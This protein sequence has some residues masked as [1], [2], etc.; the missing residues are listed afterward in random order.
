[1]NDKELR[2]AILRKM[3][4]H[5]WIGGKHIALDNIPKGFPSHVR[6]DVARVAESLIREGFIIR[7]PTSYGEHVSLNPKQAFEAKKS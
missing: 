3:L 2:V 7:K 6:N 1:M 4:M 5:S